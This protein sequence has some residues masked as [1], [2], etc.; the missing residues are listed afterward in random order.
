MTS[1][2]RLLVFEWP[3]TLVTCCACHDRNRPV[4]S[5]AAGRAGIEEM[6]K[7]ARRI[8]DEAIVA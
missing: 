5:G 7:A 6:G 2:L 8:E 4:E 3:A 1:L